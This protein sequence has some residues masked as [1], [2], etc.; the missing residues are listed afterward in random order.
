MSRRRRAGRV[1]GSLRRLPLLLTHVQR[2]SSKITKI[3]A[4]GFRVVFGAFCLE[5]ERVAPAAGQAV[6]AGS[7][8]ALLTERVDAALVGCVASG[9]GFC[10]DGLVELLAAL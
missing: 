8:V 2:R 3:A 7:Y 6:F 4:G 10:F 1:V 9:A 5:R